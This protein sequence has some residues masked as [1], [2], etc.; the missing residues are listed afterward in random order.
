MEC[1]LFHNSVGNNIASGK[2]DLIKK[3]LYRR[4]SF[5]NLEMGTLRNRRTAK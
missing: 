3:K 1:V 2:Y 5:S 4:Y